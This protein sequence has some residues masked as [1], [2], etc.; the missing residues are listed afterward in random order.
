MSKKQN[1]KHSRDKARREE[2]KEM[3]K[4]L[5]QTRYPLECEKLP[6]ETLDPKEQIIVNKCINHDELTFNEFQVLRQVLQDYRQY[7]NKYDKEESMK[8]VEDNIRIIKSEKELLKLIDEQENY[9]IKMR[10]RVGGETLILS[11]RVNPLS[12]SQAIAEMETHAKL[13][14]EMDIQERILLDKSNRDVL[15]SPEEEKMIQSLNKKI[16]EKTYNGEKVV[17]GWNEFLARQVVFEEADN[18]TYNERLKF[19]EKIKPTYKLSLYN[20]VRD[21]LNITEITDE[22]LFLSN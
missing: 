9:R 19:W 22:D 16:E 10:Y 17:Q 5:L 8:I 2:F 7:F 15:L 6:I 20:K 14:R 11:L 4:R 21:I 12:D 18:M 1:K 13:F 3:D